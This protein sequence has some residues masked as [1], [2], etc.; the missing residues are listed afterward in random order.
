MP[1][2]TINAPLY[3]D[4]PETEAL[5]QNLWGKSWPDSYLAMMGHARR[6]ELERNQWREKAEAREI[7]K[8]PPPEKPKTKQTK[9]TP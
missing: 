8:N 2:T 5:R 7:L 6:L 1:L 3:S 4:A 9:P